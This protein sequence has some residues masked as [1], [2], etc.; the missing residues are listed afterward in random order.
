MSSMNAGKR[1]S[2]KQV[3]ALLLSSARAKFLEQGYD[4]TTTREIA[5][6]AGVIEPS[7][8]RHFGSK[9]GIFEAAVMSPF[10]ELIETYIASW[11]H[12]P[13]PDT[14]TEQRVEVF[15]EGLFDL[16]CEHRTLLLTAVAHRD[17]GISEQPDVLDRIATALQRIGRISAV[18]R[19]YPAVAPPATV[20]VMGSMIFGLAL[21]DPIFFPRGTHRPSRSQL[22]RETTKTLLEGMARSGPRR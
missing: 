16:A 4:R 21:L 11:E 6:G 2:P 18:S 10:I 15:L 9:A 20:A 14:D 12:D 17:A 13:A 8:F 7:V 3:R 22:M 19:D 5:Q 1:R